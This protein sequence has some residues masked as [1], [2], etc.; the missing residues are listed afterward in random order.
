MKKETKT[1]TIT[2]ILSILDIL[3]TIIVEELNY[4]EDLKYRHY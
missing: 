4:L 3:L 2:L 1:L